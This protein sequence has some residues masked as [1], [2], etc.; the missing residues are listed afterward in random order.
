MGGPRYGHERSPTSCDDAL[1]IRRKACR[2][3]SSDRRHI[4]GAEVARFIIDDVIHVQR[5]GHNRERLSF[6]VDKEWFIP[7]DVVNVIDEAE[8]LENLQRVWR[9]TKPERVETQRPC[10]CC[11]LNAR[12]ALVVRFALLLGSHGILRRPSL[13]VA[14]RFVAALDDLSLMKSRRFIESLS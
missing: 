7:A 11:K 1:M 3:P 13:S 12:D 2:T 5:I 6:H 9:A 10:A 14:R 8:F 4:L